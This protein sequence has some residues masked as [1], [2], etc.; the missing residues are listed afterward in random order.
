MSTGCAH[1]GHFA[2]WCA[3]GVVVSL[4]V[5]VHAA[6]ESRA[7][8][9]RALSARA[10]AWGC[11]GRDLAVSCRVPVLGRR[12]CQRGRGVCRGPPRRSHGRRSRPAAHAMTAA[13]ASPKRGPA[14][15]EARPVTARGYDTERH[16]GVLAQVAGAGSE[17]RRSQPRTVAAGTPS[18]AP[19]RALPVP[20]RAAAV[21]GP[22]DHPGAVGAARGHPGRQQACAS[23][24]AGP[25]PAP[26]R[27]DHGAL[28]VVQP[29][30]P[31][32]AVAPTGPGGRR[33]TGTRSRPRRGPRPRTRRR[34]TAARGSPLLVTLR[35]SARSAQA[36]RGSSCCT[37]PSPATAP[38]STACSGWDDTVSVRARRLPQLERE[39][40]GLLR[41]SSRARYRNAEGDPHRQ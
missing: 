1:F 41:V 16:R 20:C 30:G 35:W 17:G 15:G 4:M 24:P 29:D 23:C 27:P 25:A 19:S 22:G 33:M 10:R 40:P 37:I 26:G 7:C 32:A 28:A 39:R 34:R 13:R 2:G 14:R 8:P 21:A 5:A 11:P 31:L 3:R 36:A 12:R 38:Q 18:S 6:R 9:W